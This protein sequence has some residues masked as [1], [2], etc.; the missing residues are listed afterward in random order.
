MLWSSVSF[1][2]IT[3][4]GVYLG[5]ADN[6]I[7]IRDTLFVGVSNTYYYSSTLGTEI[8]SN[9]ATYDVQTGQLGTGVVALTSNPFRTSALGWSFYLNQTGGVIN[10][11]HTSADSLGL[12]H[13]TTS[14]NQVKETNSIVDIGFHYPAMVD[15]DGDGLYD[16]REDE[17]G[18]G[19]ADVSETD[20]Q[21]ADTDEDGYEDGLEVYLGTDPLDVDDHPDSTD[22][23]EARW[24]IDEGSGTSI[25]DSTP[26][27]V[28]ATLLSGGN[29]ESGILGDSVDLD[30]STDRIQTSSQKGIGDYD[31]FT[32]ALWLNADQL[33]NNHNVRILGKE[34][35]FYF[36]MIPTYYNRMYVSVGNGTSWLGGKPDSTVLETGN[37]THVAVT[38]RNGAISFYV[39][40]EYS[41]QQTKTYDMG[42]KYV[43]ITLGNT[44]NGVQPFDGKLNDVRI[45]DWALHT[46]DIQDVYNA[47]EDGDGLPNWWE[48][49]HFGSV[50][51]YTGT[52]DPDGDGVDNLTEY[53][54]GRSPSV[55]AVEDTMGNVNLDIFT[56]RE[57]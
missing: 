23:L 47:D 32:F 50:T 8:V 35:V 16:F 34:R 27:P 12:Y 3:N 30:D 21:E 53:L 4:F 45:Y 52:S 39:D 57:E 33:I 2:G 24:A 28:N 15:T 37:W 11:G 44:S 7:T 22:G 13:Y 1:Y 36:G 18:D 56:V 14:T 25:S 19:V 49:K 51:M 46:N 38:Y 54:Q 42:D 10:A 41:S 9:N 43:Q 31:E 20:W 26:T 55:A 29:W 6:D 17:D 40:G 5:D 48:M